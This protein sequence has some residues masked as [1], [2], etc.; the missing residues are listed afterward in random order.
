M[1]VQLPVA[2]REVRW[3]FDGPLSHHPALEDWFRHCLPFPRSGGLASPEW[4]PRADDA[5]DVYLLLPGHED[6]GIKWREGLLQ[7]KGL[8]ADLGV[9]DFCGRHKG[10]VERWIKWSYGDLP[11]GYRSLFGEP[12]VATALV[13]KTRAVRRIDLGSREPFEVGPDSQP[14]I[15]LA[16]ELAKILV[17][18][19]EYCSLAFEAD[20]DEKFRGTIF[21]DSVSAFLD[22]LADF[23]LE[24]HRSMSYAAWLNRL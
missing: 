22:G 6:M 18:G 20:P 12:A 4:R 10:I 3:F 1:T 19:R 16:V 8:I 5:P 7:V 9:S 14:D 2:S 15:G 17:D 13:H 11:P 23:R 21:H 24:Q